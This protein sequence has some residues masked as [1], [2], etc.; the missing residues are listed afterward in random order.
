MG[1]GI[2]SNDQ[3]VAAGEFKR[4][5]ALCVAGRI[6]NTQTGDDLIAWL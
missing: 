5:V 1:E 4:N 2:A 6:D 3:A